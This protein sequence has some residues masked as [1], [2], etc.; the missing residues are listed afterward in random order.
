MTQRLSSAYLRG[1]VQLLQGVAENWWSTG[2]WNPFDGL[3]PKR[4]FAQLL[5]R[6]QAPILGGQRPGLSSALLA[7]QNTNPNEVVSDMRRARRLVG[8]L[9]CAPS[10]QTESIL[11]SVAEF[12]MAMTRSSQGGLV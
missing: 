8:L 12:K 3:G 4:T 2:E 6:W 1:R 10:F 11:P 5:D 9:A 7:S